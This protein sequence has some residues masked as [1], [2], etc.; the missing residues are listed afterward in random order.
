MSMKH[1]TLRIALWGILAASGLVTFSC[2]HLGIPDLHEPGVVIEEHNF[3]LTGVPISPA[4]AKQLKFILNQFDRSLY[5]VEIFQEGN[6]VETLGH[7]EPE[8]L[9]KVTAKI[10]TARAKRPGFTGWG[11][12]LGYAIAGPSTKPKPHLPTTST[13]PRPDRW[14]PDRDSVRSYGSSYHA[15]GETSEISAESRMSVAS[16]GSSTHPSPTPHRELSGDDQELLRRVR[17]ILEKYK[18]PLPKR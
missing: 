15:K 12:Q 14:S 4:D 3:Q 13:R 9:S 1:Q 2:V 16:Y 10:V 8:Y 11:D 18:R 7:L 17:P 6:R 5:Q